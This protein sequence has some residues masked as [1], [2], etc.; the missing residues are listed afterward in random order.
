MLDDFLTYIQGQS[1]FQKNDRIL[2]AVSG[3]VDS[4]VLTHLFKAAELD[5]GIA[6]C[7][8]NLRDQD[9][10]R[11]QSF[12]RELAN[13]LSM[14]FH[15]IDF[16]T[17]DYAEE[18]KISTQMA[19]RNLRYNWFQELSAN[20]S[21]Q[22]ISTAHHHSDSIETVLFNL[23][24]GTGISGVRGIKPKNGEII[25]PLLF[26]TKREIEQFAKENQLKWREDSSNAS[27]KYHRNYIRHN[28]QPGFEHINPSFEKT[29][30][31]TLRRLKDA[32][33]IVLKAVENARQSYYH[34]DG[35]N[36]YFELTKLKQQTGN[37]TIL[38]HLIKD[39]GFNYSQ[40]Q[41]II[42]RSTEVGKIF[43]SGSHQANID[44]KQLIIS[45]LRNEIIDEPIL[46]EKGM[47]KIYLSD[48]NLDIEECA[49]PKNISN[50]PNIGLFDISKISFPLTVRNWQQGDKFNPLGMTKQKKISDFLIDSK[51]PLNLKGN[52]K[53]I[54]SMDQI[55]WV[56]GLRIDNRFKLDKH[57]TDVLKISMSLTK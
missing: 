8:F 13:Q 25:R 32:E 38:H 1:L 31:T 45:P 29:S 39:F 14:P 34:L 21:Y 57:T 10:D 55:V 19:A 26:A 16:N 51:V 9:S 18:Y 12:V 54:T 24:K 49:V 44:R 50:D 35:E 7:N 3:G 6:H 47:N 52:V 42:R 27:D 2:L 5:F 20:H 11:D 46:L 30:K 43:L 48:I 15:T 33:E 4:V 22:Y 36:H 37:T 40:S 53:V 56:V 17:I 41:D 23:S 28:V